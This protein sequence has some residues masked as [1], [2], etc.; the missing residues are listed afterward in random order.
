VF[1][2]VD[3]RSPIDPC[4]SEG[5]KLDSR[6]VR[7][8][9]ELQNVVFVYPARP[10]ITVFNNFCLTIPAGRGRCVGRQRLPQAFTGLA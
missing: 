1:R 6:A 9:L 7:G 10:T 3:R 5:V 8:E 4:S 2:V